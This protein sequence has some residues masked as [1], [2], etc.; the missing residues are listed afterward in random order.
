MQPAVAI[1]AVIGLEDLGDGLAHPHVLV[2]DCRAGPMVEVRATRKTQLCKELWQ[3]IVLPEGVN[4]QCLLP[5]RQEL[6][7]DAQAFF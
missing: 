5:V 4:Q 7:I 6:Q 1:A 2:S 3:A